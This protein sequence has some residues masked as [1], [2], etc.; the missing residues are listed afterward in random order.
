MSQNIN[1]SFQA[2]ASAVKRLLN[3]FLDGI[4]KTTVL[5]LLGFLIDKSI[6]DGIVLHI[7]YA[8][9]FL[10]YYPL[11]EIIFS[12]TPG[13]M[14]TGTKVV[15]IDGNKAGFWR[16]ILR[17]LCR[18]IPFEYLSF[19]FYGKYPTKGWHDRLSKTLVVPKKMTKEEVQQINPEYLESK[20]H[21]NKAIIFAIILVAVGLPLIAIV[22]VLSSVVL[23]SLNQARNL[24]EEAYGKSIL[25]SSRVEAEIYAYDN[26]TYEGACSEV[27][28]KLQFS[29]E[30]KKENWFSNATC[31]D[32]LNQ[33]AITYK[34]RNKNL[35]IDNGGGPV[36]EKKSISGNELSCLDSRIES[37]LTSLSTTES[38]WIVY[39]PSDNSFEAELPTQPN[40][41]EN[42]KN[43]PL[44]INVY[45]STYGD[46][47]AY[48]ISK[49][50]SS[51]SVPE[52]HLR[53]FLNSFLNGILLSLMGSTETTDEQYNES[54]Y[55]GRPAINFKIEFSGEF[56]YGQIIHFDYNTLYIQIVFQKEENKDRMKQ[57][58]SS[59]KMF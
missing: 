39:A 41:V 45:T 22:G 58:F 5:V 2:P 46:D 31:N 21:A 18:L 24:G 27:E 55:L 8:C 7:L 14:L 15:G 17:S 25:S 43:G 26:N 54:R 9:I 1:S 40:V 32:S 48:I 16:I 4:L 11:F 20:Y 35:C 12:A 56:L 59:L 29:D 57:F 19:L 37:D 3:S 13:K 52:E 34:L 33:L 50:I 51:E 42:Q 6:L 30:K 44:T 49:I 36:V 28:K 47:E 10:L 38:D 53:D 23:A